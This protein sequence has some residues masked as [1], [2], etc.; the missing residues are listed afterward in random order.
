[1]YLIPN[2][3]IGGQDDSAL[4]LSSHAAQLSGGIGDD[5]LWYDPGYSR[6]DG[7]PGTD[8]LRIA[9]HGTELDLTAVPRSVFNIE[10]F[11]FSPAG[12]GNVVTLD[13]QEVMR[14]TSS[15]H[16]LHIIGSAGDIVYAGSGWTYGGT[17]VDAAQ[18]YAVYTQNTATL[19]VDTDMRRSSIVDHAPDAQADK[20]LSV[21]EDSSA[22]SLAIAAPA[23][24]DGDAL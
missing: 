11:D 7:G 2:L 9:T 19:L 12:G 6:I 20:A 5:V 23:E 10:Y 22:T 13:W 14:L 15:P 4:A 17:V 18:P 21:A 8:T 16:A 3:R 24:L 1:M